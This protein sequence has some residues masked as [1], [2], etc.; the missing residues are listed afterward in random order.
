ML[1]TFLFHAD[2]ADDRGNRI[3]FKLKKTNNAW[4][5]IDKQLPG[6]ILENEKTISDIITEEGF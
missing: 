3:V 4:K 1:L 5:I 6:W 2:V